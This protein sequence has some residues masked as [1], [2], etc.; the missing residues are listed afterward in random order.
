MVRV[1]LRHKGQH[2][3]DILV[4]FRTGNP[5][6]CCSFTIEMVNYLRE[7]WVD[8]AHVHLNRTKTTVKR[9]GDSGSRRLLVDREVN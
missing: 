7:P 8:R 2:C 6:V 1:L 3:F 4:S 5:G 9:C